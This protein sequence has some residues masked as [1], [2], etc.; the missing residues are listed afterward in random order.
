MR[1][2]RANPAAAPLRPAEEEVRARIAAR[3]R[4]TFAEFM[5]V[6]LFWPHGGY[7]A[8]G[9]PVLGPSGDYFTSPEL[10]P[11]F[12]ALLGSLAEELWQALGRPA[13][14]QLVEF[15]GGSG[16]LARDLLD[17]AAAAAPDFAARLRYLIVEP[18]AALRDRQRTTLERAGRAAGSVAWLARDALAFDRP[19]PNGLV[20]ANELVDAFP[21]HLVAVRNGRLLERYVTERD[22]ALRFAEGEPSTPALPAYFAALGL[23][24]GEGCLAEVNLAGPAWLRR[25]GARL[26]RGLALV[27]DYGYEAAE[28]YRPDRRFGTLLCYYRHTVS[29]DPLVRIGRQDITSHVDFT[30]LRQAG[31]QA[32]LRVYGLLSQAELL[33]NLGLEA[34]RE[35]LDRAPAPWPER[36]AARRALRELTDPQGLG[37]L[38]AL[39]LGR[40]LEPD[41]RPRALDPAGPPPRLAG[42]SPLLRP[43]HLRLPDPSGFDP[44]DFES[45]WRELFGAAEE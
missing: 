7:Y 31:E 34:V 41:W 30:A 24:P 2:R 29:S 21:V 6:A 26:E 17:W 33:G 18:S 13:D 22:G 35:H 14:F 9:A 27:L 16:A 40:G 39:L 42:W 11:A 15:G 37:R 5:E 25:V 28:L 12:G 19:V 8:S 45:Q 1:Q 36:E 43:H 4:I 3:G 38:R 44:A 32:G 20:I 10:H 23:R